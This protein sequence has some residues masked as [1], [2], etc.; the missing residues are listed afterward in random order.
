MAEKLPINYA[1]LKN[2]SVIIT[3]GASGLGLATTTRFAEHGAYVTIADIQDEAGKKHADELTSKGYNVTFVH[4]DTTSWTSSVAAFKHAANFS[5]R[6]TLDAAAL[7]AGIGGDST[8]LVSSIANSEPPSLEH[9]PAEPSSRI[10]DIN[11]DGVVK[12]TYLALHYFRLPA[13]EGTDAPKSTKKNLILCASLAGYVDYPSTMYCVS[14][15][16]VRGLFRSLRGVAVKDP[17]S[18]LTVNVVCPGYTQTP[19]VLGSSKDDGTR[20]KAIQA[21]TEKGL[22]SKLEHVVDFASLCAT[23][24]EV[25]G[26]SFGTFPNGWFDLMEDQNEGYGGPKLLQLINDNGFANTGLL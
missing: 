21:I 4:C 13:A 12:S 2:K 23:N 20:S 15:F 5:P 10:L 19:M 18:N 26:R 11:L 1:N 25:N 14:K 22:W 6:K 8:S 9:D 7:F 16:G 3:G 24:D 17:S